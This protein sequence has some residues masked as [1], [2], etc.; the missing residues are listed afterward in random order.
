MG[1][2]AYLEKKDLV[3]YPI[4]SSVKI[5]ARDSRPCHFPHQKLF[6]I[7]HIE[8]KLIRDQAP[9][10]RSNSGNFSPGPAPFHDF[11]PTPTLVLILF[12]ASPSSNEL[13]I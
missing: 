4:K 8:Y 7:N 13:F 3:I 6:L 1:Q 12:L 2:P 9:Y 5:A 10:K 11:T